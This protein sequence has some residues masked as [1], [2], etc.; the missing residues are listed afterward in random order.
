M[1]Q[2][3]LERGLFCRLD[4]FSVDERENKRLQA[5]Q[6]LGLLETETIPV[7]EEV[8]QTVARLLGIPVCVLSIV[9][10]A[11]QVFKAA[12]GLSA[13]G[14]MNP[15]A[16]QRRL[17]RYESFCT[18]VV[19][20][21]QVLV[22]PNTASVKDAASNLLSQQYGI[23]A[24]AGVP[25][26]TASG[27]C[28]GT[29]A[30]MDT[31]PRSFSEQEVALLEVNA[32]WAMSEYERGIAIAASQSLTLAPSSSEVAPPR[33]TVMPDEGAL[34]AATS[35]LPLSTVI[36]TVRLDLISQ[37]TQELRNPLTSIMGM[38]GILSREIYGPLTEKQKEYA[39]IVRSSGQNLLSLVDEIIGLG[40]QEDDYSQINLAPVDV[41]MLGQQALKALD[42]LAQQQQQVIQLTVEPSS[43]LW[44]LDKAKVRQLMYHLVFSVIQS[45][46]EGSTIRI[47][48]AR[49]EKGL[50]IAVWVSNPW[51]GEG[52]P[53]STLALEPLLSAPRSG[54]TSLSDL[55]NTIKEVGTANSRE[56]LGLLLSRQL[57]ELH[58]GE[59]T[60][61]G[62]VEGGHRY[63]V[64]LPQSSAATQAIPGSPIL[65][66]DLSAEAP[67]FRRWQN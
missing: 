35:D 54:S 33:S 6:T 56:E 29:L 59:L 55:T 10:H 34:P 20:S 8:T 58:G 36:N 15:L 46:E 61:Q 1:S 27:V 7:F 64:N 66:A 62:S 25:L 13:L 40:S 22:L 67:V 52:L 49:R 31:Q 48:I 51:L 12:V 65:N 3:P 42:P 14:L 50:N 45:A 16:A 11:E 43:R 24:Y 44:M 9:H 30:V 47:H 26:I 38:A 5:I 53:Q 19:D 39:D 57:A 4:G 18:H 60:M 21:A 37:L 2:S 32:R 17:P 41:E 28:I 23:S 63:V